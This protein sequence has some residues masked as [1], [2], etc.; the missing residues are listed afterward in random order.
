MHLVMFDSDGTLMKSNTLDV[1]S[2]TEALESV[3]GIVNKEKDRSH[4]QH[5]TDKG[6]ISEIV[7]NALGRPAAEDELL[8]VIWD[9]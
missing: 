4:Y 5:V 8:D 9:K 1:Q 7:A 3:I 6:I 2:F